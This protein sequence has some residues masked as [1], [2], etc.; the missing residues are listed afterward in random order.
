MELPR[1]SEGVGGGTREEVRRCGT[2]GLNAPRRACLRQFDSK[3]RLTSS[4]WQLRQSARQGLGL[5]DNPQLLVR[6]PTPATFD[7]SDDLHPHQR[8]QIFTTP[9]RAPLEPAAFGHTRKA[10]VAGWIQEN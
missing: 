9:L 8:P 1:G 2:C 3:P 7:T 5:R 10:V 4:A 6:L